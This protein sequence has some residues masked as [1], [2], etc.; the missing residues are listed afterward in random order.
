M[1]ALFILGIAFIRVQAQTGT[2][3]TRTDIPKG[4]KKGMVIM[5]DSAVIRGYIKDDIR[6]HASVTLISEGEGKRQELNGGQ[7]RSVEIDDTRYLCVKGDFFKVL[8]EG[9]ICFLQKSSDASGKPTYNGTEAVFING[10]DGSRGDYFVYDSRQGSLKL[11]T[12]KSYVSVVSE[13]FSGCTAAID[14]ANAPH[15]DMNGM[16]EAVIVYNNL[17]R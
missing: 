15:T 4:F 1:A 17:N 13:T 16:K 12:R 14:K 10:T 8:A 7:I 11:V 9:R 6:S 5:E 3:Q 2:E